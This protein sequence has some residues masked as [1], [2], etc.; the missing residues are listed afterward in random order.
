MT[1]FYLSDIFTDPISKSSHI[2]RS[3]AFGLQQ[4]NFGGTTLAHDT[5]LGAP[6]SSQTHTGPRC[7]IA[8]AKASSASPRGRERALQSVVERQPGALPARPAQP[9]LG[10]PHPC[11]CLEPGLPWL[12]GTRSRARAIAQPSAPLPEMARVAPAPGHLLNAACAEVSTGPG[13]PPSLSPILQLRKPSPP[14]V[15]R[16]EQFLSQVTASSPAFQGSWCRFKARYPFLTKAM[17]CSPFLAS[18]GTDYKDCVP[19]TNVHKLC[20]L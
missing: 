16:Q 3:W 17:L 5:C 12:G 19:S 7:P 1:S 8:G 2:L 20:A 11:A 4:R 6:L 13:V 10:V 18:T 9:V 15:H 14:G